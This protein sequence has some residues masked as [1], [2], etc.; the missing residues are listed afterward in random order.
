MIEKTLIINKADRNGEK[1]SFKFLF[2]LNNVFIKRI[3]NSGIQWSFT[4]SVMKKYSYVGERKQRSIYTFVYT[5][6]VLSKN[7]SYIIRNN[8]HMLFHRIRLFYVICLQILHTSTS[9]NTL[10]GLSFHKTRILR[11]EWGTIWQEKSYI[12][13]PF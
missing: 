13:R 5:L 11:V 1:A 7:T 10:M 8:L 12:S 4:V 2:V 9:C 6:D 3:W